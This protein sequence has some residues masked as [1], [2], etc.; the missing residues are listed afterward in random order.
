[1]KQTPYQSFSILF[2]NSGLYFSFSNLLV[3]VETTFTLELTTFSPGLY[4]ALIYI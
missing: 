1:M 3:V 4:P 2:I